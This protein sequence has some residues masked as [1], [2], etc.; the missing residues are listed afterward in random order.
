MIE[1]AMTGKMAEGQYKWGGL[2]K[3]AV[4]AP[5]D[6]IGMFIAVSVPQDEIMKSVNQ[7]R[8]ITLLVTFIGIITLIVVIIYL[9]NIF[10]IGKVEVLQKVAE[11]IANGDFKV[12]IPKFL[13]TGN[14]EISYL[15]ESFEK[16]K[17]NM[18]KMLQ[19][20]F[21]SIQSLD[22]ADKNMYEFKKKNKLQ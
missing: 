5:S 13:F 12:S 20:M 9:L 2:E 11:K 10:V 6:K 21:G 17:N 15:A 4:I 8:N 22:Q 16:M 7:Q 19:T 18:R 14:D 1:E 3:F